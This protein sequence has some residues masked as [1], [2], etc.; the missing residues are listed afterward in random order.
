MPTVEIAT[1]QN[2]TIEYELAATR[3]RVI[4]YIID[5]MIIWLGIL[6]FSTV[7]FSVFEPNTAMYVNYVVSSLFFVFYSLVSELV[8]HGQSLGKKAL[9]IK[10]VRLNGQQATLNDYLVRWVFRMVDIYFS[11]G[12][13]AVLMISSS[14]KRQ[15]LGDLLAGMG[16][17]KLRPNNQV[18]LESILKI[19][20]QGNY[21]VVYPAV[22][23]L[24]EDEMVLIKNT[25]DRY[26]KY[27]N[28]AHQSAVEVLVSKLIEKLEIEKAPRNKI[29]FLKTLIRDYIVLTR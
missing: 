22:R 24:S 1:T 5:S 12:A 15:R 17:V 25:M 6:L 14:D 27:K 16:V 13:L 26:R 4:A 23:Q 20:S 29:A 3:D 9:G 19:R 2:V 7:I 8:G 18:S 28:P 21:E 11:V 10:V